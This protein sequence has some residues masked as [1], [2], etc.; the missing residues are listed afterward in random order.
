[1]MTLWCLGNFF[2]NH[3]EL[4]SFHNFN[5]INCFYIK[6]YIKFFRLFADFKWFIGS[7]LAAN[8][9]HCHFF[10]MVEFPVG[11]PKAD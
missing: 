5:Y 3:S 4:L 2:S 11:F 9:Y 7:V 10:L 8:L 1:M 6:P